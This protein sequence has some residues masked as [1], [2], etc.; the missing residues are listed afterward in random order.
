MSPRFRRGDPE[1]AGPKSI[2]RQDRFDDLKALDLTAISRKGTA[3]LVTVADDDG[4]HPWLKL[5]EVAL[6]RYDGG[7][8]RGSWRFTAYW[9]NGV[10]DQEHDSAYILQLDLGGVELDMVHYSRMSIVAWI[11][12]GRDGFRVPPP[13][14]AKMLKAH[15]ETTT[16][17]DCRKRDKTMPHHLVLPPGFYVPPEQS[18]LYAQMVGR[19]IEITIDSTHDVGED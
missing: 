13:D 18:E 6:T 1:D 4:M 10:T 17:K 5:G 11:A 19:R 15:A 2:I 9:N 3:T 14:Y 7:S 12:G 8:R 16:C